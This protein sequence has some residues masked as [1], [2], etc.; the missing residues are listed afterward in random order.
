MSQA[1]LEKRVRDRQTAYLYV[2]IYKADG[3][4]FF[5]LLADISKSGFK[6]TSESPV[7]GDQEFKL[8]IK[9][10]H[11]DPANQVN[12]FVAKSMWSAE[13]DHGLHE[14]GFQFVSASKG[15]Q[16]LFIKLESDFEATSIAIQDLD[17]SAYIEEE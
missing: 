4:S 13:K 12:T 11:L 8:A 17:E 6:L 1:D 2:S 16:A 5:G 3:G 7:E 15:A 14:T 9:N 10:P